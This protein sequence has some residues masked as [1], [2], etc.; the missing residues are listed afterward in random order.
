LLQYA[1]L[2]DLSP[3]LHDPASED[4]INADAGHIH[5]LARW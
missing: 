2:V 3:G 4:P 5:R 1:K